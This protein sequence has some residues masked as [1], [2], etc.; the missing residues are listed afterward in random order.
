MIALAPLFE[1]LIQEENPS[2][3]QRAKSFLFNRRPK[4]DDGRT[5]HQKYMA[6]VDKSTTE[7]EGGVG[8]VARRI[9]KRN[10]TLQQAYEM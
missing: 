2:L 7:K 1:E 6:S 5:Q 8:G 4:V 10:R 9:A 3:M